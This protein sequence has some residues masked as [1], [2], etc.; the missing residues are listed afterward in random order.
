MKHLLAPLA[1]FAR[2]GAKPDIISVMANKAAANGPAG[3]GRRRSIFADRS[4]Y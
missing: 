3:S 4:R 2:V 1:P